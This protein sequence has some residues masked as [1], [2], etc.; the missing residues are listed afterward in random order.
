MKTLGYYNGEIGELDSMRVPMLDR[1]CYFGDG[2]YDVTY[3][4]NFRIYALEEH[5]DRF[6]NSALHLKIKPNISKEAF[7][8]LLASLVR[9]L[10]SGD[11][12]IYFQFSRGTAPRT[13]AF[14]QDTPPNLWIMIKPGSIQ[15]TYRPLR[16]ITIEDTRYY[17]CHIKTLNLL[18]NVLAV[19]A[20]EE[21]GVDEAVLH[22]G[23]TVTECAHSNISIVKDNTLIT[24]PTD[25][26][27]LAGIGR[28][29]LIA[30][31]HRF[32]IP[33]IERPFTLSELME[34]DEAYITSA[35]ALCMRVLEVDG[36][37]IG[38]RNPTLTKRL[39][40][41]LLRDYLRATAL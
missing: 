26:Y 16:C 37:P 39:Q 21:A 36:V 12:W 3:S 27:I 41:D 35:S 34:A 10:D 23:E 14:P 13:H 22:R 9:R 1:A 32:E 29:H 4:R 33:V 20:T 30:S 17:H 2:V 7:T 31:C 19:Q 24:H 18:P 5:V 11:L 38:G 8:E 40:D 6:F 28:A 25:Q 15:D